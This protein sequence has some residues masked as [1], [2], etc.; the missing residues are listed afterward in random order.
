MTIRYRIT[1]HRQQIRDASTRK[2]TLS[3]HIDMCAGYSLPNFNIFPIYQC[4]ESTTEDQRI[5]K[6]QQ[7]IRKYGPRLNR[8]HSGN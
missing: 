6:E 8:T 5:N 4:S 3:E 1:V 2:I 7:F